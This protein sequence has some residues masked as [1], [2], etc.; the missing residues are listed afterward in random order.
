MR[1]Q[2][3]LFKEVREPAGGTGSPRSSLL[4]TPLM[5][6]ASG[7][8]YAASVSIRDGSD[9]RTVDL[10]DG[11]VAGLSRKIAALITESKN[12]IQPEFGIRF[13]LDGNL[14]GTLTVAGAEAQVE[15]RYSRSTLGADEITEVF[16]ELDKA[17][18]EGKGIE[19]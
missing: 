4:S 13:S 10:Y 5:D 16:R 8:R 7:P 6:E 18:S 2:A 3:T 12:G 15:V 11:S 19:K 9:F 1:L 14:K 17:I